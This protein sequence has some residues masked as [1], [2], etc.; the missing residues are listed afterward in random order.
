MPPSSSS[1]DE[2]RVRT[3]GREA[4]DAVR[5][6]FGLPIRAA[7]SL[8]AVAILLLAESVAVGFLHRRELVDAWEMRVAV[9]RLFPTGLL[10]AA[11][12]ALVGFLLL[13][14]IERSERVLPRATLCTFAAL[15]AG[16]VGWG[17]TGGRH[18]RLLALRIAFIAGFACFAA[19]VAWIVSP[20][21]ASMKRRSSGVFL[22]VSLALVVALHAA[23]L[24]VL[25]RLY[26]AFHLALSALGLV[27]GAWL[28]DA[29]AELRSDRALLGAAGLCL[30]IAGVGAMPAS[31]NLRHWDN[32]R[33]VYLAHAPWGSQA[34]LVAS[35][36]APADAS[37]P[38]ACP[39]AAT[40]GVAP[41]RRHV[42]WTGRD[43]LL[44]SIDALRADHVGAYGYS[45]PITPNIDALAA[46]G[47]VFE[48]AYCAMPHTSYSVTSLMTG[49]YMRPLLLQD[50]GQDSETLAGLMRLYGYRTSAFYP[51]A[52]FAIDPERFSWVE[53]RGL[54]FEYRKVEYAPAARRLEQ[55]EA[56]LAQAPADAPRLLWAHFFEPHEPYESHPG[57]ELG[58]R[59]IDRY[60][61]EIAAA[62]E[63]IGSLVKMVRAKRPNT[64]VI[65]TSDHG[66]EF[67]DHGGFYHGTT[68][69]EEQVRVP[70]IV[71][72]EGIEPRR[73]RAPVQLVDV[74]PT[75]LRSFDVPASPRLRGRDLGAALV[76]QGDPD[77]F[78][79]SESDDHTMLAQGDLRLVCQRKADACALYDISVDPE[80]KNNVSA[81]HVEKFRQMRNV[82]REFTGSHGRYEL[83][84]ARQEGKALP[85]AI[86]R[87]MAGDADAAG[88]IAAMLDDADVVLRRKA[89]EVLFDLHRNETSAALRLAL[90]RDEDDLVR[91]WCALA[92]TRMGQGAP[93]AAELLEDHDVVWRRLAALAFAES[94]DERG[95]A[96]LV[97]WWQ[98]GG[99]PFERAREIVEA[100]GNI[101]A[102][103][104][105]VP[106]SKT[107]P[108]VRLRPH[109]ARALARIGDPWGRIALM[110]HFPNERYET[111]RRAIAES[112]VTLGASR[113]MAQALARF[114]GVPDPLPGG[115]E[116]AVRAK[117]LDAIGGPDERTLA[118]LAKSGM[119]GAQVR[120]VVPKGGNGKGARVIAR[121]RSG[122][123]GAE[124]R[125]G[126]PGAKGRIDSACA[127]VL[128]SDSE[129]WAELHARAPDCLKVE[130]GKPLALTVVLSRNV[131][132]SAIAV[133]PL[134]DELPPPAPE[135][136]EPGQAA[137]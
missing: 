59:D 63:A 15:S 115:L 20:K 129:G 3:D 62:D 1:T 80:Q 11:P 71:S 113:E 57:H 69:Y 43:F 79:F 61:S 13:L 35:R 23:N 98:A 122:E 39:S 97:A 10:I 38:G 112:L 90:S 41:Q 86:R 12:L 56:Y 8:L 22:G 67:G 121:M 34:V 87:G 21:I 118:R 14:L 24:L 36:L 66:E 42:D 78:A 50:T 125:V 111:S 106:M 60:D 29:L 105:V 116:I 127:A 102:K 92:L 44:I 131:E 49:K 58:D 93:R 132:V 101:K 68:V 51:P 120:L 107:L 99:I 53:S 130:P 83:A 47:V 126:R 134:A 54:D 94:G 4:N 104:A 137:D 40:T 128:R 16:T 17:V 81:P 33:M 114:L 5:T 135:P 31:K 133:V 64:V 117:I 109:I 52:I 26:P 18:F 19:V 91:R 2:A 136:W 70:L 46:Q 30:G 123:R 7:A 65:L 48:R 95:E 85:T 75:I 110:Q 89:A 100:L 6:G 103:S 37:E 25:P 45:R 108:D 84:G 32:V 96:I 28:G 77:G 74:V 88:D 73:V 72:A 9:T 55:V 82:L 76:G 119:E 27:I 124:L